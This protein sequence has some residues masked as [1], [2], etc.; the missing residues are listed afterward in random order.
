MQ[1]DTM[2]AEDDRERQC[3]TAKSMVIM[4]NMIFSKVIGDSEDRQQLLL[5]LNRCE[6]GAEASNLL[7]RHW[8]VW[9]AP[10][11]FVVDCR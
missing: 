11:Y 6:A 5:R 4:N 9:H 7:I 1:A 3:T 8:T 2:F 10:Y